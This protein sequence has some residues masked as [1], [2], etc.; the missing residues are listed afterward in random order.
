M[1][2]S[3]LE[4]LLVWQITAAGLP[5]PIREFRPLPHRRYR[6]DF[7]YEDER[8]LIEVEGAVFARKGRHTTGVGF[9]ADCVKYNLLTLDGWRILRFTGE[10]VKSGLA[11][12]MIEEALSES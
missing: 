12:S 5:P 4:D 8:L 10:Q 1:S 2:K 9:T 3:H 7:C 11:L 6:C